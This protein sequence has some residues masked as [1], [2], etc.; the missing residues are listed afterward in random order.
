MANKTIHMT[1]V[2]QILR[3]HVQ[4]AGSK[5]ISK[6]TGVARNTVKRYVRQFT[7]EAMTIEEIDRMSDYELDMRFAILTD[8]P[9]DPRLE[10]LQALFPSMEKQ[11]KRR[12]V[13]MTQLWESYKHQ[14]PEGYGLTQFYKY[15][16]LYSNQVK[17][18]MVMEH[19]AGDKMYIDYAGKKLSITDSVTGEITQVEVYAA[20]LGCSQL[21]YVQAI[22][23]QKKEHLILCSENALHYFGGVPRAIVPDNLKSAVTKSSKYEPIINESFASFA[24]HYGLA[25][26]PARA[27]RPKDKSLVEGVVKISYNRIY[28][29]I[30][31]YVFHSLEALNKAISEELEKHNNKRF[32]GRDYS[33]RALFEEVER[34]ALNPL[35]AFRFELLEYKS[36]TVMKNGHVCLAA[37]K[38]YYSVPYA[39]IGKKVKLFYNTQRIEV[40]HNYERIATH[41]R[42][43]RRY[44]Y[45]T[46]SDHLATAHRY[47]S[48]W[49]PEKFIQQAAG[50]HDDVKAYIIAILETK[51][52]PEQAYKSCAGILSLVRKVGKER[53]TNACKR[54]MSY[55]VY[56]YP[57]LLQ[58]LE[59]NLDHYTEQEREHADQ[60]PEHE[61]IRGS[62][63]YQ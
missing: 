14:Y 29:E 21:T 40:F 24:E 52:H 58:I 34:E 16:R 19:K 3:H 31:K 32:S 56:N 44:Q 55:E 27:Y 15:Y 5:Q 54:A 43:Q 30:E 59:K 53:L 1:K 50:I 2:R 22:E 47:V 6:L 38:H 37:D 46:L 28:A 60:M 7:E 17:P 63:Y 23:S 49:T 45:T 26:L 61:N 20:I 8:I 13:T 62:E 25:V 41:I 11:L 57:I 10:Q 51:A 4:G 48:D 39:F 33:R 12:G 35:P 18:V 36:V 42:D 9:L